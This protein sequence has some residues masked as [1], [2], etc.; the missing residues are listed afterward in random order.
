MCVE[1]NQ[2]CLAWFRS[3]LSHHWRTMGIPKMWSVTSE[4][5]CNARG[6]QHQPELLS[7]GAF[8]RQMT[9]YIPVWGPLL[10]PLGHLWGLLGRSWEVL[11]A[12]QGPLGDLLWGLGYLLGG[13]WGLL[14]D[15]RRT[16]RASWAIF[17]A[18]LGFFVQSLAS[19]G[20]SLGPSGSHLGAKTYPK[21][22]P[23]QAE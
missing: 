16:L 11:G 13:L 9:L 10:G 3:R 8:N 2:I 21:G 20:G 12:S 1:E 19:L 22:F 14:G 6:A 17:G 18:S 7:S 5:L 23:E 15:L 4:R